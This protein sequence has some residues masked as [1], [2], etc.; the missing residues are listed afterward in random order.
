VNF[1]AVIRQLGLLLLGLSAAI[2]V[3]G[4]W[5]GVRAALGDQAE[6]SAL[7]ALAVTVAIGALAGAA[8]WFGTRGSAEHIGRREAVLLVA[9]SWFLAAGLSALPFRLW[10]GFDFRGA[11][12]PFV[13]FIDCY[14]EA[15]SGLTTTGATVLP[16]I[17]AL[18][19]SLLLWRSLTQWIGGI[20]IVVLFVAVLPLMGI[21][22]KRLFL[23]ESSE[24]TPEGVTPRVQEAARVLCFVYVSL[25][26][27]EIVALRVCG[28]PW[29]HAVCH[30]FTTLATGGF[31]TLDASVGGYDS[32]SIDIVVM[33]FMA[34]AGVNFGLYFQFTQRGWRAIVGDPEFRCYVAILAIGSIVLILSIWGTTV[35]TTAGEQGHVGLAAAARYGVF[36]AVSVQ[37]TTG[38]CTAD[39]DRWSFVAKATMLALMF[40]GGSAGSTGGGI[41]VVRCIMAAKIIMAQFEHF[42]RPQAV[43]PVKVGKAA[44]DTE[45]QITTLVFVLSIAL[46]TLIGSIAL[47]V[48][49]SDA[50]IDTT[51][52]VSATIATLNNIG[53]GLGGVGATCNFGWF[54][55]DSKVVMSV[56]MALGRLEVLT[57]LVLFTP[58][59]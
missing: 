1:R 4:V 30:S 27:A 40:V 11:E 32:V 44:I 48:L 59:F 25:T 26:V 22:G 37:T 39:F 8:C 36:Q 12:T 51:T 6:T 9:V 21:G 54:G 58:R 38:F 56:L 23:A 7:E 33:V 28:M 10:A 3:I 52:A 53:P 45:M 19:G 46:L 41:K 49:E 50:G 15:M 34:A 5:A 29:F 57:I 47:M 14:F 17:G 42:F 35:I 20:G 43:R 18:P 24:P 13:Q 2:S 16:E 31:S 55:S